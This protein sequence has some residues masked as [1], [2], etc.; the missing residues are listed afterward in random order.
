[1]DDQG[2]EWVAFG[3]SNQSEE[4]IAQGVP[5]FEQSRIDQICIFLEPTNFNPA[6]SV[7]IEWNGRFNEHEDNYNMKG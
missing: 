6:R 5:T 3:L 1:M 7:K 4:V 2:F